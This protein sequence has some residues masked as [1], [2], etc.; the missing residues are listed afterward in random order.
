MSKYAFLRSNAFLVIIGL[1]LGLIGGFKVA[2]SQ[3][4]G[5]RSAA[6]KRDIDRAT[7]GMSSSQA[8]VSAIIEKAKANPN[9]AEAQFAAAFQ[10]I[11][12]ERPQEAMPFLEQAK[13][14]DPNDKR[15]NIGFG[16]AYFLLGQYDQAIDPLKRARE[17]GVDS[18]IVTTLLIGAYIQT[19]KNL[20]EA[21]RLLKKLETQGGNPAQLAQIRADLDAART[22]GP[23]NQGAA[24]SEKNNEAQKP[25]TVLSH[26]PEEPKSV[27]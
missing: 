10:F 18:P 4:R 27:K 17:Q 6:L 24:P 25:K 8:D 5:E 1:M 26:G 20:D 21:E 13:M 16:Y 11:Q 19:K 3:Y 12:I 22:G 23:A 9:D 14:A 7:S 15:I 2:N